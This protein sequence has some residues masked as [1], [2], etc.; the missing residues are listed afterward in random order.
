MRRG[1]CC[2]RSTRCRP[3]SAC[4]SGSG[5][6]PSRSATG[7]TSRCT[8][9][10]T[11]GRAPDAPGALVESATWPPAR[12]V[13]VDGWRVGLSGGLTRRAN[14]V[15]PLGTPPDVTA[16]L[17]RV[18]ELYASEGQPSIVRVCRASPRGLD[19]LLALRDYEVM[20][21]T[22]VLVRE[23]DGLEPRHGAVR[24]AAGPVRV[25]V[26]DRP[27]DEWLAAWSGS[28][29][30]LH[31]TGAAAEADDASLSAGP[32][33][34]R[35]GARRLP[36]GDGRDGTGRGHPCGVRRGVGRAVVPRRRAGRS[37]AR[38][39]AVPHRARARRGLRS[40]VPGGR[41]C[42]SRPRT[43]PPGRSTRRSGFQPAERYV[44]RER[45]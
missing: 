30:R 1:W 42:R 45:S 14:S 38:A 36:H 2:R 21:R 10:C 6:W 25:A 15:L 37:S 24:T 34:A 32:Q 31:A 22:D 17:D 20:S 29:A 9:A 33:R 12:V 44:Y 3:R 18:E 26:A 16:T 27:G 39:R 5:S 4:T 43:P 11:R 40:G 41:S 28:K 35:R 23:L 19:D 13:D 8:C 7:G